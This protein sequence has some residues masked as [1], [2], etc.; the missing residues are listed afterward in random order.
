MVLLKRPVGSEALVSNSKEPLKT[1]NLEAIKVGTTIHTMD[2]KSKYPN[3]C[4][5]VTLLAIHNMVVVTSPIGEKAPPA[6]AA[7][8]ISPANQSRI[9][10]S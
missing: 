5:V 10:R 3:R 9:F 6:L 7:T 8:T 2:G 4:P 1:G